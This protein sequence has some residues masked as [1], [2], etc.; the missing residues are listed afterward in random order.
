VTEREVDVCLVGLGAAGAMA[1][2]VLTLAGM[3]VVALE[4]GPLRSRREYVMDE[5][6]SSWGPRYPA[7]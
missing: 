4:A 2:Y 6:L 5:L 1:A 3:R 7:R